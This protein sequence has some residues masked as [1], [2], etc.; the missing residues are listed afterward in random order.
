MPWLVGFRLGERRILAKLAAFRLRSGN[1][2]RAIWS[3]RHRRRRVAALRSS[4]PGFRFPS[5]VIAIAL[6]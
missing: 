3:M 6:C 1:Q 2:C 5:E 4:F